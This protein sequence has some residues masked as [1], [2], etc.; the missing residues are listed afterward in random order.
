VRLYDRLF[1]TENPGTDEA[2]SFLDELNPDSL[3]RVTDAKLE[4][5]LAKALAV[6]DRIQLERLGY[7]CVD[8]DSAPGK[9]VL[10][11]TVTL[12]D[13]WAK[14]EARAK[15]TP[16]GGAA[17][18]GRNKAAK[19]S[20]DAPVQPS[21]KADAA[22][23]AKAAKAPRGPAAEITIDDFQKLDLRVGVVKEA[24]L[25]EGADKLLRLQVDVGEGR[26]RQIMAGIRAYYPA[27]EKLVG[28]R[29]I[30]VANLKPRQMKFGLSE[31][32]ILAA[33]GPPEAGRPHRLAT[34]AEGAD[35]PVA[36]DTIG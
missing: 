23:A 3:V 22:P 8:A 18:R 6:G 11:R 17:E 31:G 24:A 32:M 15:S 1:R 16:G 27:P 10:N 19:G 33:G 20:G 5:H 35:A 7:F 12:K 2:T 30:V 4:P 13:T 28:E 29:V 9:L 21:A 14:L 25:V 34:F 26:L 36:G